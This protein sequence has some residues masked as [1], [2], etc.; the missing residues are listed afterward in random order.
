MP[1][2]SR[3]SS[4]PGVFCKKGVLRYFTK[5][6]GKHLCLRPATLLK[7]RLWHICFLVNFEKFLRTPF[8]NRTPPWPPDPSKSFQGNLHSSI[9]LPLFDLTFFSFLIKVFFQKKIEGVLQ[10]FNA[11]SFLKN[12]NINRHFSVCVFV[13]VRNSPVTKSS[14]ET[15]L[16]KM[17]SYFELLT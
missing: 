2:Q 11:L 10:K 17:T 4:R 12:M 5:F 3:S 9:N 16:R 6:T 15:E 1:C 7:K 14:Y 13:E 8:F